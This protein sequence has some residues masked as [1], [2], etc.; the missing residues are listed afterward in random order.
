MFGFAVMSRTGRIYCFYNKDKGL[1]DFAFRI[2]AVLGCQ[3]S[4]DDGRTWTDSGVEFP[5]GRTSYDHPD[6]RVPC[7]CIVWQKPVR[8]ARGRPVATF[9]RVSSRERYPMS[10]PN[11]QGKRDGDLQGQLMRFDNIDEGPEPAEIR[12]TWLPE[13]EGT[14]RFPW[15]NEPERSR[16]YSRL[17]EPSVG[18]LPDGRMLLTASCASGHLVYS[19]SDGPDGKRWRTPE[20]LLYRDEGQALLHPTAPAPFY[21]LEDGRYLVF[22]HAHDGTKHGGLGPRDHRGRRPMCVSVGEYR[23]GARQPVW[24]SPPKVLCDTDGV[25]VGPERLVWLA[26]YTSLTEIDGERILWYPDRKHFLLGR[27]ITDEMLA[28]LIVPGS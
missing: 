28:E 17:Y 5:Y 3:T 8:D 27:S 15:P 26:M 14:L 6:P 24:F 22:Y 10:A 4:D 19:V 11:A 16:G 9:T 23:A 18:V 21:R 7:N 25:G 13:A 20:P 12:I 1:Y 2:T